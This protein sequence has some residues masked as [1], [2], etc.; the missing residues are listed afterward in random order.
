[1]MFWALLNDVPCRHWRE[2]TDKK[3]NATDYLKDVGGDEKVCLNSPFCWF[4][5]C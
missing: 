5:I 3:A 2:K 4:N 1:M